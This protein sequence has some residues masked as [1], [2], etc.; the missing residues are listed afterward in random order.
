MVGHKQAI[1]TIS[2]SPDGQ[3]IAS[4]G[5]DRTIRLWKRATQSEIAAIATPSWQ[6]GAIALANDGKTLAGVDEQNIIRLWQ[7]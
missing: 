6:T 5:A 2:F 3:T 4:A 1:S 7:I